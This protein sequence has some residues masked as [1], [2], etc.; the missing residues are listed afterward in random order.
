MHDTAMS[1]GKTFFDT[2]LAKAQGLTILDIGSLDVNGA[3]RSVAPAGNTFIGVDFAEGKGVD[4]V[5]TDPYHLPFEDNSV[6][7]CVS[8]SCFEHS[9]FFWLVFNDILRILKPSGL[10]YINVPSNGHFHRYPVDCWRFYPD[11]GRALQNWG[12]RSGFNVAML[13]SF[14]GR[15]A[16]AIWN[17]FVA[18]FVKDEAHAADYPRRMRDSV[19]NH[20]N[21]QVHGSSDISNYQEK[22]EDQEAEFVQQLKRKARKKMSKAR[23]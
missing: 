10:L 8:S 1:F 2:Y 18:V 6:D 20:M 11:S 23:M 21:G 22:A 14:T 13:E 19:P 4:R 16:S 12:R 17:D 7:A 5:I 9:E 15:Q 3:L